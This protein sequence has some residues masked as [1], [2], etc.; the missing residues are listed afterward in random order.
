M[1]ACQPIALLV[2]DVDGTLVTSDK[3]LTP[4]TI[5]AVGRLR[6]AGIGFTIAS[7][8]PPVGLKPYVAALALE[9]PLG[10]FNGASMIAPDLTTISKTTI[11]PEAAREAARRLQA[12]GADVWVFARGDWILRDPA[13]PFTDLERRTI[14]VEPVVVADLDAALGKADKIVG[15]SADAEGLARLEAELAAMLDGQAVVKRSQRYYLDVTPAGTGKGRFVAALSARLGIPRERIATIGDGGN[16]VAMFRAS[17]FSIAMGN[18]EPDVR[19]AADAVTDSND[20][21]G[22]ARAIDEMI[23]AAC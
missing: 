2:S 20:A 13:A 22:L 17:G 3:T 8:R 11:T 10:A 16:D 19:A 5:A 14:G 18:A 6:A 7:A 21:D 12:G 15:V 23:L 4:A 9:L 1:N